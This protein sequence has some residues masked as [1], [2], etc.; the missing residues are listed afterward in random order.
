MIILAA[1]EWL[2]GIYKCNKFKFKREIRYPQINK[3]TYFQ[4]WLST[5]GRSWPIILHLGK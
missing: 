3:T 4:S 2:A 1:T 5:T